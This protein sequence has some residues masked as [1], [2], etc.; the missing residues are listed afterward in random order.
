MWHSRGKA[1]FQFDC[2]YL[3]VTFPWKKVPFFCGSRTR[4]NTTAAIWKWNRRHRN[5][6]EAGNVWWHATKQMKILMS[7]SLMGINADSLDTCHHLSKAFV[8]T[9]LCSFFITLFFYHCF[10]HLF[11]FCSS[12]PWPQWPPPLPFTSSTISSYSKRAPLKE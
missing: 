3:D 9:C 4:H 10:P 7:V 5:D 12:T 8:K 6:L 1:W 2:P 11:F